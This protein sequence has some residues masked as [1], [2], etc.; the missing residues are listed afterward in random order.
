MPQVTNRADGAI[1]KGGFYENIDSQIQNDEMTGHGDGFMRYQ[2]LDYI[3]GLNLISMILYHLIWDLVY[4]QGVKC[5]WYR[6][7]GGH[8]W[9]QSICWIFILLSGFCWSLGRRKLR[10]GLIVL[11]ASLLVSAVTRIF[12]PDDRIVFGV[13]TLLGS[14]MLLM[15][16]AEYLLKKTSAVPGLIIAAVCF[17]VFRNVNSGT[18][19]FED[20]VFCRLPET[21]YRNPATAFLGFPHQDFFS[22]D[23]FSLLPWF[24]LFL[25]GY[26]CYRI[27][28]QKKW[29][30]IF[31]EKTKGNGAGSVVWR[32]CLRFLGKHSLWV[33]LLH[34]PVIYVL[35]LFF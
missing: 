32:T 34:Q 23:Y 2:R 7:A 27:C 22:A 30:S 33:Y 24:F 10:R 5:A 28:V 14:S 29:L 4:L 3:R 19:G 9:Q 17:F 15:I 25:C 20:L 13:L 16:P 31:A 12:L 6:S 26:F 18:L 21:L 11:G 8:I 1:R 35:L